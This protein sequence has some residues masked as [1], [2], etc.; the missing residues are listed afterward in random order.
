M[1][2]F[3]KPVTTIGLDA[4]DTVVVGPHFPDAVFGRVLAGTA[5]RQVAFDVAPPS[6]PQTLAP[7]ASPGAV[8]L[9]PLR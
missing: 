1:V 2:P 5:P 3:V 6:A 8:L 4:P 9:P 7:D